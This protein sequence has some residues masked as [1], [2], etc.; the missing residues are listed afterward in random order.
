MAIIEPLASFIARCDP[1]AAP[2][3]DMYVE[4]TPPIS[5]RLQDQLSTSKTSRILFVGPS[6]VGKTTELARFEHEMSD[7]YKVI[8]PPL[9]THLDLSIVSWHD[10]LIL[11]VLWASERAGLTTTREVRE[12]EDALRPSEPRAAGFMDP[13]APIL[14]G[15]QRFRNDHTRV[16]K[17]IAVGPAQCWD[18]A[19]ALLERIERSAGKPPLLIFDGLERMG[20]D[21]AKQLYFHDG[22]F[23]RQLP[24]RAVITAP[25]AMSFEPYFGDIEDSVFMVKRLRAFSTPEGHAGRD[26]FRD[27]AARRHADAVM[28]TDLIEEAI[29]W[30]GGLP[31]QFLALLAAAAMQAMMEG[32]TRVN[33][34]AL[35]R[36]RLRITERWLYQLEPKDI[37]ALGLLDTRRERPDRARL[38]R[39]GALVEYEQPDGTAKLEPNP[40]VAAL[41]ERRMHEE[42]RGRG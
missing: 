21:G 2:P 14:S 37:T 15:L 32:Q 33:D 22:R 38:L 16:Q 28:S 17:A 12:L 23:L 19:T 34:E 40:L 27:L 20:P 11:S 10:L 7:V 3:P 36:A 35:L 29:G 5:P 8:R 30:S 13:S 18:L 4:R 1:N 39:L 6:G 25:L 41:L 26:F 9:E 24:C 42:L 31:R